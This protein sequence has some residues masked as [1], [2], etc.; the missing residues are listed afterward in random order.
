[1]PTTT[2]HEINPLNKAAF[3][4]AHAMMGNTDIAYQS[5]QTLLEKIEQLDC[6]IQDK[7]RELDS[8]C[9]EQ[10]RM[11]ERLTDINQTLERTLSKLASTNNDFNHQSQTLL[12]LIADLK[13]ENQ[14]LTSAN[15]AW[16]YYAIKLGFKSL[17]GPKEPR[18]SILQTLRHWV[19][20]SR[21]INN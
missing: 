8:L 10:K 11:A 20:K 6:E 3:Q 5:E 9:Q 17:A 7:N 18:S 15:H 16:S 1:M 14:S 19:F 13:Q 12:E 21:P 2:Q 4:P